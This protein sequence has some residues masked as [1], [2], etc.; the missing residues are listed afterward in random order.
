MCR[1]EVN[2]WAKE[3]WAV[4]M[5]TRR[6]FRIDDREIIGN[7]LILYSGEDTNSSKNLLTV[8]EAYSLEDIMGKA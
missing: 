3:D 2:K 4:N 6:I 1:E 8:E 5:E 7:D